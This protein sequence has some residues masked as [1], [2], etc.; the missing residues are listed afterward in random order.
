M[1]LKIVCDLVI[2]PGQKTPLLSIY[3][4]STQGGGVVGGGELKTNSKP[5]GSRMFSSP[6][7][8]LYKYSTGQDLFQVTAHFQ[9]LLGNLTSEDSTT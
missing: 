7:F 3:T 2:Q 1:P 4:H 5:A 9:S 6:I 8:N